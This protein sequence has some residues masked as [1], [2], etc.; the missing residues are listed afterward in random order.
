M[1]APVPQDLSGEVIYGQS[2]VQ[3]RHGNERQAGKDK[4]DE[5]FDEP[6][7]LTRRYKSEGSDQEGHFN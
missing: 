7:P 3:V 1:L 6:F 2:P 4:R 5:T